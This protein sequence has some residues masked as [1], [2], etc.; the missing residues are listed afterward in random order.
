MKDVPGR[1]NNPDISRPEAIDN[2]LM[3]LV[4]ETR[5]ET[6]RRTAS[7]ASQYNALI[8]RG[9]DETLDLNGALYNPRFGN[10][11]Y[12][13][14]Q[15]QMPDGLVGY[16]NQV[17]L[18]FSEPVLAQCGVWNWGITINNGLVPYCGDI[19]AFWNTAGIGEIARPIK[20]APIWVQSG[21]VVAVTIYST[22]GLIFLTESY[23]IHARIAGGL[24]KPALP[25]V[26][27]ANG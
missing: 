16:I 26:E 24:I 20:V 10:D 15:F 9:Y 7:M 4:F 8:H 27:A 18:I 12:N 25:L 22:V 23:T 2:N 6:D 1:R 19:N 21:Q 11:R 14:V 13:V 3:P 17:A 5:Q